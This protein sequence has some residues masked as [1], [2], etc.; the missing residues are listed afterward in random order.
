MSA[1]TVQ[2][3]EG[4]ITSGSLTATITGDVSELEIEMTYLVTSYKVS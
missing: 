3:A 4:E 1:S 2:Y